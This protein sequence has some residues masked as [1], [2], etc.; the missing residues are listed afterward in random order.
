MKPKDR[1]VYL[2]Y[3]NREPI[4]YAV[5]S[6]KLKALE[7]ANKLINYRF[8]AVKQNAAPEYYYLYRED[9]SNQFSN[10]P[11]LKKY[12][13]NCSLKMKGHSYDGDI[14]QVIRWL[15]NK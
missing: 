4:V 15:F 14:V 12:I 6:N 3:C 7:Y 13:L 5:Y 9:K 8:T 1:F 2:V 11:H 10:N